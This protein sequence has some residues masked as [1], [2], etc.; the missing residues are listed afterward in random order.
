MSGYSST[1]SSRSPTRTDR[2][3]PPWRVRVPHRRR[4][5][6]RRARRHQNARRVLIDDVAVVRLGGLALAE[7]LEA[8]PAQ[9]ERLRRELRVEIRAGFRELGRLQRLRVAARLVETLRLGERGLARVANAAQPVARIA[10]TEASMP[11]VAIPVFM[12]GGL[13]S[14]SRN[15]SVPLRPAFC[16]APSAAARGGAASG[17]R[18]RTVRCPRWVARSEPQASEV[19]EVES[20]HRAASTPPSRSCRRERGGPVRVCLGLERRRFQEGRR[21]R[22]DR[23]GSRAGRRPR[24]SPSRR[25]SQ[26]STRAP[27]PRSRRSRRTCRFRAGPRREDLERARSGGAFNA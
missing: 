24:S 12:M 17:A 8:A 2:P 22:G 18:H 23:P 26:R 13:V 1:T 10:S 14:R 11:A 3:R 15:V 6:H 20:R 25:R 16:G 27:R 19:N 7:R 5:A 9:H 21:V 4:A